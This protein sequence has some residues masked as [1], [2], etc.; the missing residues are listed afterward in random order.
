MQG[1]EPQGA[2]GEG[3][4]REGGDGGGAVWYAASYTQHQ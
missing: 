1:V 3:R 2:E 4:V